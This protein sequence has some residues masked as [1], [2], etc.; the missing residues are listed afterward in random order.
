MLLFIST[1]LP[2]LSQEL[3]R[4]KIDSFFSFYITA[5][6]NRISPL[7][8][9]SSGNSYNFME[10]TSSLGALNR[11]ISKTADERLINQ[12]ILLINNI[13]ISAKVSKGIPFNKFKYKDEYRGWIA[14]KTNDKNKG[15]QYQ[16]VPLFESYAFFSITQFL[17]LLKENKWSEKSYTNQMWWQSTL[18]FIEKNEWTKWYVRS[19]RIYNEYYRIFLSSRTHMGSHWAGVAMYLKNMTS[20]NEIKKQCEEMQQQYDLLLK[21]N[22]KPN[23]N[24][25]TAYIWNSTYDN[26][27][28]TDAVASKS[29]IVQDVSHGNHVVSYIISAFQM[30]DTCWHLKD[31]HMLCRTLTSVI[32]NKKMN[33]FANNVDGSGDPSQLEWG[34][35]VANGWMQLSDYDKDVTQIIQRFENSKLPKKYGQKLQFRAFNTF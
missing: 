32:Y 31:I 23:P 27:S 19:Y 12:E 4:N 3:N 34:N 16:E 35:L 29:S 13:L 11:V 5:N 7:S 18:S 26:V 33:T 25:P 9:S 30:G 6:R 14:S 17:Y 24:F 22:L 10:L 15:V 21:R 28:G 20:D 1:A 8:L 2:S